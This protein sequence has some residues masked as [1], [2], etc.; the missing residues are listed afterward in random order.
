MLLVFGGD[1]F[2]YNFLSE[3]V[4]ILGDNYGLN[5]V[6]A[7]GAAAAICG[8]LYLFLYRTR[9]GTAIRAVAVDPSAAGL[10]AIDVP[11]TSAF[12]FALGGALTAA[13]GA[14]CRPST[15]STPRWA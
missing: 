1:Y 11:R 8:C 6:V 7:L 9:Y 3:P 15:P 13:G 14:C 12:A 10:V 2:T 4:R 5:R